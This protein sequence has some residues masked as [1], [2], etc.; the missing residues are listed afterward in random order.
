MTG[1][2]V[3]TRPD[4]VLSSPEQQHRT[5]VRTISRNHGW[6]VGFALALVV[7]W[8]VL[9][10][11]DAGGKGTV[12]APWTVVHGLWA[13]RSLYPAQIQSTVAEA[14]EG[15]LIAG[16]AGV[17]LGSIFE[18]W[19]W[20]AIVLNGP[21]IT[22]VCVPA[23]VWAPLL[24][25]VFSPHAAKVGLAA[26]AAFLP[27]LI[28]TMT[29][30]RSADP[31][32][33]EVV[34]VFGGSRL[35]ELWR[36]R[37]RAA[38]PLMTAGFR[39][40]V[41]GAILGATIGEFV[42]GN[43]GLGIFMVEAVRQYL[44]ARVWG[45]GAVVTAL[46]VIGYVATGWIGRQFA[47]PTAARTSAPLV[48]RG[49]STHRVLAPLGRLV[50]G[51]A[52]TLGAW[53]FV[54]V[55]DHL[56]SFFAKT[57]ASV[58]HFMTSTGPVDDSRTTIFTALGQTGPGVALGIVL[59]LTI[60]IALAVACVADRRVESMLLPPALALQSVPLQ[61]FSPVLVLI[62]GR[63]LIVI[64]VISVII[65]FF[66]TVALTTAGLRHVPA[67][68]LDV[69][70]GCD[71]SPW[72]VLTTLRLPA[73]IP[74]IFASARIAIPSSILGVLVAEY[75][76]TSTGIGHVMVVAQSESEYSLLWSTATVMTI[77]SVVV[78]LSLTGA[79]RLAARR[80]G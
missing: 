37:L 41:P 66:P 5:P 33:V 21:A 17:V 61:A 9:A 57:P 54:I 74:S 19:P 59:G 40:A 31:Q 39:V 51:V 52:V 29:G 14:L 75:L 30:L 55:A 1:V 32:A 77:I 76:A 3:G 73:A 25:I 79:E 4:P 38:L 35:D 6:A 26:L 23:L 13:D 70:R 22:L 64:L 20:T 47:T 62:F 71:A 11:I 42:G 28:G 67:E 50:L 10:V 2:D 16:V 49:A 8:S 43:Q 12:P 15:V 72:Q 27:I 46:G 7:L 60:G 80:F 58:W 65:S 44:P 18:L 53:R 24:A 78:Y 69:L 68:S 48:L 63:G 36:V 45:A 56:D 34:R